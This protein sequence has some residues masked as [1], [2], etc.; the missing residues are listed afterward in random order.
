MSILRPP[1]LLAV[2]L[3]LF[4]SAGTSVDARAE[5]TAPNDVMQCDRAGEP[6]RV[7]CTVETLATPGRTISWA[8]VEIVSVPEFALAL[9]G[10]VGPQDATSKERTRWRFALALASK[11]TGRGE[12]VARVRV[13]ECTDDKRCFTREGRAATEIVVG[14]AP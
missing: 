14:A 8:E 7:R 13:V 2:C 6:G 5:A 12:V 10:R 4:A 9:R 11:R 1:V 3:G